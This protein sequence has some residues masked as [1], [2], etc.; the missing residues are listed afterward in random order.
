MLRASVIPFVM[1]GLSASVVVLIYASLRTLGIGRCW[2]SAIHLCWMRGS[3]CTDGLVVE[4]IDE[5]CMDWSG[6]DI[7]IECGVFRTL[8]MDC[9]LYSMR[10]WF[11]DL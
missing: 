5:G 10:R 1:S 3:I 4:K 2:L 11:E 6:V 7:I 8:D 9:E